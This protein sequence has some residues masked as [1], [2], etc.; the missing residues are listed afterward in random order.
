MVFDDNI[1]EEKLAEAALAI[2]SLTAHK[3]AEVIRA[4]KGM[5]W[6]LLGLLYQK[7]RIWQRSF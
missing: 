7:G 2:L 4:W 5:D 6:D 1:D 3:D